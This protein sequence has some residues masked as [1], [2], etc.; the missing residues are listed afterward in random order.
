MSTTEPA[1]RPRKPRYRATVK[2]VEPIT[3]H[4]VR[5]TFT[6]EELGAFGW[7]GP[8][9]HIKLMFP[10]PGQ[11]ELAMPGPDSPRPTMR[12][13]TPRKFDPDTREL[14]VEFYVHG[15][16]PASAWAA[17]ATEGQSLIVAGPG[18]CYSIDNESPW[19]LLAGD[20]S[21]IPAIC[22][23]L[24]ALPPS[25]EAHVFIE[26]ADPAE[27]RP[28][29]TLAAA[30]TLWLK[31]GDDPADAGKELEKTIRRIGLPEGPGR[32]YVACE[33]GAVR[34]IRNHLLNERNFDRSRL[35]T[36]GYWKLGETDHPDHDYGEDAAPSR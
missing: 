8:A 16:G 2:R 35:V 25:T 28:L 3:P 9:A 31:R 34:R 36:R 7:N 11:T 27:E 6:G 18:R 17:Q 4:I 20:E 23:I 12:T 21:S 1:A 33:S 14:D 26:V 22:T 29:V 30:S 32:I 15:E 24:E 10:P 5:V 13:Y 19:Y